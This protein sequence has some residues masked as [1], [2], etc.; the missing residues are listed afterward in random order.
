M[1]VQGI[2]VKKYPKAL[3]ENKSGEK[4]S[5]QIFVIKTDEKFPREL[6]ITASGNILEFLDLYD[7][8]DKIKAGLNIW[9][10]E[11]NEKWYHNITLRQI[12]AV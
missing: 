1:E 3:K 9:S 10:W 12:Q 6:A 7:M 4:F 2:I 8:D 11:H 5:T